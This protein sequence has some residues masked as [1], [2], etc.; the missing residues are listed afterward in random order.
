[1][2]TVSRP[3][4]QRVVIDG[5]RWST[6]LS[7]LEDG[8]NQRGRMTFDQGVLEIMS[9]GRVHE[10]AGRLLG[11]MVEAFTEELEIEVV[12]VASTTFKRED[13]QRGFEA[14]EAYYIQHTDAVASKGELDLEVD[15]PPDLVVEVDISRSSI[16]KLPLFYALGVPEIWRYAGD[17]LCVYSRG[18]ADYIQSEGSN[19]LP[20][21]PLDEARKVMQQRTTV[22]ETQLIRGFRAF[23][24]AR[25][26]GDV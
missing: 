20:Q 5:V 26:K 19:A 11:R 23:I 10:N 22:G 17:E 25:I 21:F 6:Y 24:R 3:A 4:E 15:P 12:S 16:D 13:V 18:N 8:E 7:L 9:P 14:D 1:M 2:S